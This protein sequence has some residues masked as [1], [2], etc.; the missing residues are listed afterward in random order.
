[1]KSRTKA[2]CEWIVAHLKDRGYSLQ[3]PVREV[4]YEIDEH[5][6]GDSRTVSRY[7]EKIVEYGLMRVVN[8]LVMEFC[9]CQV[10]LEFKNT[11]MKF[12]VVDEDE[13]P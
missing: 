5:V 4:R 9:D 10:S 3:V 7:L 8:P 11:L 6:G 1:M 13:P 12:L 2:K